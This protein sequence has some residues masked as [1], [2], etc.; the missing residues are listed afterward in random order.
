MSINQFA[1]FALRARITVVAARCITSLVDNDVSDLRRRWKIDRLL[2]YDRD[3]DWLR[4]YLVNLVGWLDRS[5]G[6][7][8]QWRFFN[9]SLSLCVI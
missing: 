9:L 8:R 6:L 7:I 3:K 5:N 1:L 2:Y 4:S